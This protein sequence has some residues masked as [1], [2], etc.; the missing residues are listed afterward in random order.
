MSK[1]VGVRQEDGYL[2]SGVGTM[3]GTR[4][5]GQ[6]FLKVSS[7]RVYKSIYVHEDSWA[8]ICT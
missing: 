1:S 2:L 8:T 3:T 6:S 5:T 7:T 4:N